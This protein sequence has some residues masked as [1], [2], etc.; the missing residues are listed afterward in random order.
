MVK[1]AETSPEHDDGDTASRREVERLAMEAVMDAE[2]VL[3]N[4]PRDV[5]AHNH[6][7]DIESRDGQSERLR[8]IEVKGRSDGQSTVTI[9]SNEIK[10]GLNK[11]DF[12]LAVV[13][14]TDGHAAEPHYIRKPFDR[15]PAWNETSVNY[16]LRKLLSV[17]EP[18][19]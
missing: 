3:G 14:V 16:D 6:G 4:E 2:R 12:L 9:T 11:E 10:Q 1:P 19:A 8:L 13:L 15:E 17:A 18:P 5:S 7:W